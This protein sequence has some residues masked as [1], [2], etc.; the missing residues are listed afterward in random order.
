[1]FN[2]FTY[3]PELSS[4]KIEAVKWNRELGIMAAAKNHQ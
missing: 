1:M 3:F 2:F 4:T